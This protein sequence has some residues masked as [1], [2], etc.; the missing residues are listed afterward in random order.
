M[1]LCFFKKKSIDL[2]FLVSF[3]F[4]FYT[5][6]V[7]HLNSL[8]CLY[9]IVLLFVVLEYFFLLAVVSAGLFLIYFVRVERKCLVS[10]FAIKL[11]GCAEGMHFK[12]G[13]ILVLVLVFVFAF[14]E[15]QVSQQLRLHLMLAFE[16][17]IPDSYLKLRPPAY[18]V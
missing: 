12:R 9:Q 8:Y 15:L 3:W 1:Y 7:S 18:S 17:G 4:V 14:Q 10:L 13:L 11:W 2:G 16:V 6:Y 5:F